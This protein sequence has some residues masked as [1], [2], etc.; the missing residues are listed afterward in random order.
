MEYRIAEKADMEEFAKHRVEFA[1][2]IRDI[3]EA[4]SF[5]RVTEN[6]LK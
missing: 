2:S 3:P 5:C 1:A 4:K 6:Y